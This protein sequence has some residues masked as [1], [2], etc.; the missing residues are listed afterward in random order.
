[1]K[2]I[3]ALV[4]V[5]ALLL[6]GLAFG[7]MFRDGEVVCF[8]GDSI[9]N[10][11]RYQAAI[12]NYYLTRFPDSTIHFVN[13][14]RSG[15]TAGGALG[16]MKD[17]VI[18]IHPTSVAVMFGMN[19][20]G[21]G[22]YVANPDDNRL[23]RQKSSLE[24]YR[25]N[26]ET[27]TA[28]IRAEAGEPTLFFMTPSPF[29]QT[30]INDR[31]NNQPGCN[32]GLGHCAEIVRELAAKNNATLIEFHTPMTAFNLQQQQQDAHD[33]IVGPDRVHPGDPGL[34]MMA[35]LFLKDQGV[36]SLVSRVVVDAPS[37][38]VGASEN[39]D[40]S[41]V[42]TG[43]RGVTF[44]VSAK[45]L[46]FPVS[47]NAT[48]ILD[49]LPIEQDLNQE[50]LSVTGLAAGTYLLK[51]DGAEVGRYSAAD[52]AKSI[53][54]GFNPA[55]PQYKQAQEVLRKTE[56]W[57]GAVLKWRD[58][59]NSRRWMENH[60]KIDVDDPQAV[61]AH[62][63][64]FTDK[65]SYS[66]IKALQYLNEWNKYDEYVKNSQALERELFTGRQPLP[67]VYEIV[68]LADR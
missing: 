13:S 20:V 59:L 32:D 35:W 44:T 17:D 24:G 40:V 9:T 56:Q 46:P 38:K 31:N 14:G 36:P 1:M 43:P 3:L 64:H 30:A 37:G 8:L 66:A 25:K 53:S 28:R 58:L 52:L 26:M 65:K 29:D 12:Q 61:Q 7:G 10:G 5:A 19:D 41:N 55:T 42:T 51:I 34:L 18:D 39:A 45:S 15:D 11:G 22:N 21:R 63:D 23:A 60:Y 62:Y 33:T 68:L 54:L 2:R 47:S 50:L 67:H 48:K 16:R 4:W 49:Q 57:R 27:L 6:P